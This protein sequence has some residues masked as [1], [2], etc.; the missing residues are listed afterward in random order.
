MSYSGIPQIDY[1]NKVYEYFDALYKEQFMHTQRTLERFC[2][3]Q[4]I[5]PVKFKE[6][7]NVDFKM[8]SNTGFNKKQQMEWFFNRRKKK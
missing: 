1:P 7:L 8:R 4:G 3:A 6:D 2:E 5:D